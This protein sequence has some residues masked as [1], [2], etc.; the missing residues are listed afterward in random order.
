MAPRVDYDQIAAQY[1]SQPYRSKAVDA[2]LLA[3]LAERPAQA[4]PPAI[5]DIGCGTGNQLVANRAAL[6]QAL[7][8]GVDPFA[9][10]LR[11]GS[12]KDATIL[13][14]QADGAAL[15]FPDESF[16]FITNQ[17]SFHHV[18]R[19]ATMLAEIWRVLG[20]GGRFVM[21]NIAP[22]EMLTWA[23]YRYFPAALAHDLRDFPSQEA[24]RELMTQAGFQQVAL[25]TQE[26]TFQQ[27]LHEF[28]QTVRRRD[29]CS[30]LLTI[31]PEEY[32]AGLHRL[33]TELAQSQHAAPQ[34]ENLVC[35]LS[36]HGDKPAA[37]A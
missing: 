36:V 33:E 26:N 19:K 35:V 30:Q 22:R 6:P 20:P 4:P 13:W 18:E 1:D 7:M 3:F 23:Y 17:F 10:M 29:T 32:Q 15:P 16:E 28:I 11:Q 37:P 8:V 2:D 27:P 5:L 24:L 34:I 25:T 31:L 14:V 21:T 9:G 12:R